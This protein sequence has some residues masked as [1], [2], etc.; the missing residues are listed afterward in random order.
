[1]A[2]F[3]RG[4][5]DLKTNQKIRL[6]DNLESQIDFDGST[7][8]LGVTGDII[9][10]GSNDFQLNAVNQFNVIVDSGEVGNFNFDFVTIGLTG[11]NGAHMY[12]NTDTNRWSMTAHSWNYTY[13]DTSSFYV[14]SNNVEVINLT[15]T[16]QKIGTSTNY[17]KTSVN[18]IEGWVGGG[19]LLDIDVNT[20]RMGNTLSGNINVNDSD[21]ALL[22]GD[23]TNYLR[24]TG[25]EGTEELEVALANTSYLNLTL[26]TQR[27][28]A[29]GGS[30]V[31][32]N[33]D[34]D[35]YINAEGTRMLSA[36][37]DVVQIGDINGV[38]SS[39]YLK[40]DS[41]SYDMDFVVDGT[42]RVIFDSDGMHFPIGAY[43]NEFST[44]GTLADN[45]DTAVPTEKA[46]KTYVDFK[47]STIG[48]ETYSGKINIPQDSTS[49][50]VVFDVSQVDENYSLMTHIVNRLDSPPSIYVHM[51]SDY[52]ANGFTEIFSGPIDSG[53]Y[54]LHYILSRN[55]LSSSSSSSRSSSSSS[56]SA[57]IPA[58]AR[59]T[60][61]DEV[62]LTD[63]DEIR[64]ID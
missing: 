25:G 41:D 46:T 31:E 8:N 42:T 16:I 17:L 28:G 52:D 64:I 54:W 45:S 22:S 58:G 35:V 39:T 47:T 63:D 4:N 32:T 56:S 33:S 19:R 21:V 29:A 51:T 62:R 3:K 15:D 20:Q 30:Y 57:A 55:E 10:S 11:G 61:D 5:L 38:T 60:D 49:L 6:G 7:L 44:D 24:M 1:M 12:V 48:G 36:S 26:D 14:V 43:V 9:L 50:V 27:I 37:S 23:P 34:G 2:K 59:A 40:I 18:R 53:N 13:Q